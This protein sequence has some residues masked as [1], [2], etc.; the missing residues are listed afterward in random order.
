MLENRG[1]APRQ[2]RNTLVFLAADDEAMDGLS[3]E[4]RRFLAW[5]S[6]DRDK[7]AL[8]LDANQRKEASEGRG[9]SDRNVGVRFAEAWR[10][11]LVP[12]QPVRDGNV[13]ELEWEAIQAEGDDTS[14]IARAAR[15]LCANDTMIPKWSPAL[16]K[17]ELDRWFWN[18]RDRASVKTVWDALTA[19]CYLPRLLD[20]AV[21]VEAVRAGV[22]SGDYIGFATS[23]SDDGRY[24][25]LVIGEVAT[26]HLDAASVLVKPDVARKQLA[27]EV[28]EP[29]SPPGVEDER[30]RYDAGK[31]KETQP[32]VSPKLPR[33]FF[34]TIA[35]N[36]DRPG[37][38]MGDVAEE[39]LQNLTTLPGAKVRVTVEI[40]AEFPEGAPAD[41][42][43]VV[44]ENCRTLG[45]ETHGFE[46]S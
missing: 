4:V 10:W 6:V 46:E 39:V 12:T 34:G 32:P 30:G 20:E 38:D 36:P 18:D 11:L 14:I 23:V 27:A 41:T 24:E 2:H 13:G 15:R 5:Q 29:D 42:Q 25:G 31:R 43:R 33:R 40:E 45:F 28:P 7:D 9:T 8:N 16:L 26:V 3:H 35:V 44:D 19:Y 22:A 1:T 17:M 21:F 37:R